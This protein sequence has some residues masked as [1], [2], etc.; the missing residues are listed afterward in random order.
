MGKSSLADRWGKRAAELKA[1]IL[2]FYNEKEGHFDNE[3]WRGG[4]WI[5]FPAAVLPAGDRMIKNQADYI[6][7]TKVLP[8]M[9]PGTGGLSYFGE[10]LLSLA[11][12]YNGDDQRLGELKSWLDFIVKNALTK[13]TGHLG[14]VTLA[15]DFNGDG[16]NEFVN[17]TSIPHVWEATVL[18]LTFMA[19]YHPE[20]FEGL[21]GGSDADAGVAADS[22]YADAGSR[23]GGSGCGCSTLSLD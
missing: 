20:L 16:R 18:S 12:A 21:V 6:R 2:S 5:I 10:K 8:S 17:V 3:G 7:E 9:A 22:S 23:G 13:E 14:E 1:A 11:V 4:E 19:V 15:G